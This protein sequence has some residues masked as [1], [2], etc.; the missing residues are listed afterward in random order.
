MVFI[1][2]DL[3]WNMA[4][5]GCRV[6]ASVQNRIPAEI[7]EIGACRVDADGALLDTFS[8][9]IRP[10]IYKKLNPWVANLTRRRLDDLLANGLDFPEAAR[11]FLAWCGDAAAFCSWSDSDVEPLR[12]NL[13]YYG[14]PDRLPAPCLDIQ[15]LFHRLADPEQRQRSLAYAVGHFEC[16]TDRPF[17]SAADDAYY[18]GR[19]LSRLLAAGRRQGHRP[20]DLLA[21]YGWNPNLT[22]KIQSSRPF[23]R[24]ARSVAPHLE[25]VQITCPACEQVLP[26]TGSPAWQ[27]RRRSFV[28]EAVCP[29]HGR[30]QGRCAFAHRNGSVPVLN[31]LFTLEKYRN[32][33]LLK[34]RD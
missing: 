32:D 2:F 10:Q 17:H 7:T 18:T 34:I 3:E 33:H 5:P 14:M 22:Y 28:A 19:V 20:A 27:P 31:F 21:A 8:A 13:A 4:G 26:L 24:P 15:Y 16:E 12:T 23:H 11:A 1:V 6:P 9:D 30:V 29:E 25:T